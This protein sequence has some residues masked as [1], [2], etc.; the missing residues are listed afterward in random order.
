MNET[1]MHSDGE[2]WESAVFAGYGNY[3]CFTFFVSLGNPGVNF[4]PISTTRSWVV[5][6]HQYGISAQPR[7]QGFFLPLARQNITLTTRLIVRGRFMFFRCH[8][9]G[10]PVVALANEFKGHNYRRLIY[11]SNFCFSTLLK[12]GDCFLF[13]VVCFFYL[14]LVF[15][16]LLTLRL[17]RIEILTT[18]KTEIKCAMFKWFIPFVNNNIMKIRV[19]ITCKTI[20]CQ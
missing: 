2:R 7:S 13:F 17:T 4:K 8:F 15:K 14:A 1:S 12:R 19:K 10:K 18:K 9:A 16:S 11:F 5:L 6:R 20:F 3:S